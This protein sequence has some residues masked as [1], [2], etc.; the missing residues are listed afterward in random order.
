MTASSSGTF[1]HHRPPG[2]CHYIYSSMGS[3]WPISLVA[4]VNRTTISQ[5][6]QAQNSKNSGSETN[7]GY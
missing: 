4:R 6:E 3:H 1:H 5:V 7:N 2:W